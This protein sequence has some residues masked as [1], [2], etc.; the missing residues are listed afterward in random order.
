MA[1]WINSVKEWGLVVLFLDVDG[2][3]RKSLHEKGESFPRNNPVKI[4]S[5][6]VYKFNI[7]IDYKIIRFNIKNKTGGPI[8]IGPSE[9]GE[10][11]KITF[12]TAGGKETE[13]FS[14]NEAE[15]ITKGTA[16]GSPHQNP[17]SKLKFIKGEDDTIEVHVL[18]S[19]AQKKTDEKVG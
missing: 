11:I 12:E 1:S 8:I 18:P 2:L 7:E 3:I 14:T 10:K 19:Y 17:D 5:N 16:I 4:P 13:S 15:F 6:Q 9:Y